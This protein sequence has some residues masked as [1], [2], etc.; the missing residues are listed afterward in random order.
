MWQYCVYTVFARRIVAEHGAPRLLLSL[1]SSAP[2]SAAVVEHMRGRS[3]LTAAIRTQTT[4][5][6]ADHLVINTDVLFWKSPHE[7]RAYEDLF[8]GGGP[9]LEAG[10]LLS[11]PEACS[12]EPL[13]LPERYVLLLGTAPTSDQGP[14]DYGRY[15]EKLFQVAAAAG[16]PVIFKGHDLAKDLD[17]AWFAARTAPERPILRVQDIG[18]NRELIDRSSLMV[19]A[20]STLLYYAILCGTPVILVESK[21]TAAIPDEFRASPI[22]RI[23]WEESAAL[24]RLDWSELQDSARAAKAWFEENYCLQKGADYMVGFL[25]NQDGSIQRRNPS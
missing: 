4:S 12:A 10:C 6:V 5:R 25:L 21:I 13:P 18:R 1:L 16:L 24:G 7:R 22:R 20:P 23:P 14:L 11:L 2:L 19:S 8:V 3:V 9:R 17:D 15:N